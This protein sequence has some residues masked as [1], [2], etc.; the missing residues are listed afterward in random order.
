[1]VWVMGEPT[2]YRLYVFTAMFALSL[3][4]V[5]FAMQRDLFLA[6]F[7]ACFAVVSGFLVQWELK[8]MSREFRGRVNRLIAT[9]MIICAMLVFAWGWYRT[10]SM[11]DLFMAAVLGGSLLIDLLRR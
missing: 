3:P 11:G 6:L 4:F 9:Y 8:N 1:M 5:F 2:R 7:P 10:G